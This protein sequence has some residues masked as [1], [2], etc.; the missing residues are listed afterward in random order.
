M[1]AVAVGFVGFF[2]WPLLHFFLL[3]VEAVL[4]DSGAPLKNARCCWSPTQTHTRR[5]KVGC[6]AAA[7]SMVVCCDDVGGGAAYDGGA[8]RWGRTAAVCP[9]WVVRQA[10]HQV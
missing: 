9:G 2:L 4:L 8:V 3:L 1:A 6:S 5:R 7:V 10:V